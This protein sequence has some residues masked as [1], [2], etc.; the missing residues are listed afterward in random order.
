LRI[1]VVEDDDLIGSLLAEMLAGMGHHVDA[2]V[3][4]EADAIEAADHYLPDLILVDE[5]LRCGYGSSAITHILSRHAMPYVL[6]SGTPPAALRHAA[7][8]LK[9]PFFEA[10]LRRAIEK[11]LVAPA[12]VR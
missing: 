11:A 1:L 7:V 9:K 10:D 3:T 12:P 5:R 2:V 8:F 4:T 6:M